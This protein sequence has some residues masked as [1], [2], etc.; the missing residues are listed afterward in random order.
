[1]AKLRIRVDVRPLPVPPIL[2][3]ASDRE[4]RKV[5]DLAV[6]NLDKLS[7]AEQRRVRKLL[8]LAFDTLRLT[9]N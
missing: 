1:M 2:R 9:E 4:I 5:A 8:A 7:R 6:R 3:E